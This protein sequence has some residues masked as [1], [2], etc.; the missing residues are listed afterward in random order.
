LS[1][2]RWHLREV[3]KRT[4]SHSQAELVNLAKRVCHA[5]SFEDGKHD[6]K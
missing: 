2:A 5:E 6:S 4:N 1:T 3:F